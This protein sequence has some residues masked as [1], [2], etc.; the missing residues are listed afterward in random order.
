Y[1]KEQGKTIW[2]LLFNNYIQ[3]AYFDIIPIR[4][5][6][7]PGNSKLLKDLRNEYI[8]PRYTEKGAYIAPSSREF[9]MMFI[10]K[11]LQLS[12]ENWGENGNSFEDELG[13][14]SELP[15]E[16]T[17]GNY[18]NPFNPSTQIKYGLPSQAKV[19][20]KIYDILGNE[21]VTLVNNAVKPEGWYTTIWNGENN[22]GKDVASGIYICRLT[23]DIHV[24]TIK[25]VLIR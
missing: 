16:F 3:G 5:L 22:F 6:I 21:V 13:K 18:P 9:N 23:T 14:V 1:C 11:L 2:P 12:K 4:D 24:Q 25:L 17:L 20:L 15:K 7:F 8:K 19:S 10:Q